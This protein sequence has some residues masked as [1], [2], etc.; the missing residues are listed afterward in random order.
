MTED[1]KPVPSET[2][3][4]ETEAA[5]GREEPHART[6][7][8]ASHAASKTIPLPQVVNALPSVLA[9]PPASRSHGRTRMQ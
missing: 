8:G 1:D 5:L 2:K 9:V 3:S 7:D 4:E 6:P